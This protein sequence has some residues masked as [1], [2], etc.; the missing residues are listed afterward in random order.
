MRPRP[1]PR[2]FRDAMGGLW[3]AWKNERN[4][5]IHVLAAYL[6]L[7]SGFLLEISG[8]EFLV[9]L[10]AITLVLM[11]E[12]FNTSVEAVVDLAASSFHPLARVAKDAAAAGVL[13]ASLHALAVGGLVFGPRLALMPGALARAG[14]RSPAALALLGL[15]FLALAVSVIA[16]RHTGPDR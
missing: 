6:A 5:R 15:V 7:A 10:L 3:E 1:L 4:M 16:Y 13:L 14:E 9:V 2:S 8:W 12:L 11:A